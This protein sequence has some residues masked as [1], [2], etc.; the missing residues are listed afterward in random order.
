LTPHGARTP[1]TPPPDAD[2]E[3]KTLDENLDAL[4]RLART[5]KLRA[6]KSWLSSFFMRVERICV[7]LF[8][9]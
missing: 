8:R 7:R 1:P 6:A 2:K 5:G 4:T 9:D 3:N